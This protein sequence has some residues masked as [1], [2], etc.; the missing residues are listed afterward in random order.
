MK[1]ILRQD[2]KGVGKMDEVINVS[3]GYARNF[4]FP[5]NLAVEANE[6]HMKELKK[7]QDAIAQKG[8]KAIAEAQQIADK[9]AEVTIQ[10]HAKAGAG[11]KL[12]GSI[13][14]Q[15]IA[16]AVKAQTGIDL[17]KRKIHIIDPIK[18]AGSHSVPVRLHHDVGF[19]LKLE[20]VTD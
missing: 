17:D 13:T 15:D 11:S 1:V 19:D 16:D 12:Y 4:L 8:E 9:L 10:V 6:Q 18:T 5:K 20:V 2:I 3:P 7:K 14:S